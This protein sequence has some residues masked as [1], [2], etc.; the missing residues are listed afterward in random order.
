MAKTGRY[1]SSYRCVSW[2]CGIE[3]YVAQCHHRGKRVY[4]AFSLESD[5]VAYLCKLKRCSEVKLHRGADVAL[6][7]F[8]S[9][10]GVSWH[11]RNQRWS[12]QIQGR[13]LGSFACPIKAAD[14]VAKRL[15]VQ[16]KTLKKHI[17]IPKSYVLKRFQIIMPIVQNGVPA[18]L[19]SAKEHNSNLSHDMFA[20]ERVLEFTSVMS[21]YDPYK[22]C[23]LESW[24]RGVCKKG[25]CWSRGVE[26]STM[27][28]SQIVHVIGEACVAY[29]NL[30]LDVIQ[31]WITHCGANVSHHMGPL[32]V[33]R[34]LGVLVACA[35]NHPRVLYLGK[36]SKPVRIASTFQEKQIA[37]ARLRRVATFMAAV[38]GLRCQRIKTWKHWGAFT[39]DI[40]KIAQKTKP[41]CLASKSDYT[42]RWFAR[43]LLFASGAE[44]RGVKECST[45]ECGHI[46]PDAK[47]WLA[48]FPGI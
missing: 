21:K 34:K 29:S 24:S 42:R 19:Q 45:E 26:A 20:A 18:D 47:G 36:D 10:K 32:P 40:F 35:S 8:S 17:K 31:P 44:C 38:E 22:V 12:A 16:R 39:A 11:K 13:T 28:L 23:L 25:A 48:Y 6:F 41:P 37:A 27:S 2:H 1:S 46:T 30:S 14:V 4:K 33:C 15:G 9:F 3:K 43:T 5:A 7:H